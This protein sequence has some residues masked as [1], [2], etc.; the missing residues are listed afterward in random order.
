MH[1]EQSCKQAEQTAPGTNVCMG[2]GKVAR[3]PMDGFWFLMRII[4]PHAMLFFGA[5]RILH[6][7]CI[8]SFSRFS[9]SFQTLLF[10]ADFSLARS[11]GCYPRPLRDPLFVPSNP[12][13]ACGHIRNKADFLPTGS[14]RRSS[15]NGIKISHGAVSNAILPK[16]NGISAV[17]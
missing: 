6:S 14:G 7:I 12:I 5:Q 9:F 8:V 15:M 4:S 17:P 2:H 13:F 10:A 16:K 1:D 11:C 3:R